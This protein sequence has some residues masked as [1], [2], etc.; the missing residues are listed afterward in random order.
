MRRRIASVGQ[1]TISVE[2]TEKPW[3]LGVD[4]LVVT[5]GAELGQ[6][7]VAL[8]RHNE[9]FERLAQPAL[10]KDVNTDR[11]VTLRVNSLGRVQM[12]VLATPHDRFGRVSEVSVE[13]AIRS[14][15]REVIMYRAQE[16]ALPL[17]AAGE[18]SGAPEDIIYPV[19][20]AIRDAVP[21][22]PTPRLR[23]VVLFG[24]D[25]WVDNVHQRGQRRRRA[26]PDSV[27]A[28]LAGG[29]S[30]DLVDPN[31]AIPLGRDRLGVGTYA[32]ML[33]AVIA[34]RT[35]ETPLSVGVFG[36][37]GSGKS[38]FMGLVHGQID[39]LSRE[40]RYC[41]NVTQIGF[42]AWHYAEANLW[43]SLADVIFAGLAGTGPYR[44]ELS[45]ELAK[46]D[47]L[48]EDLVATSERARAEVTQLKAE[49]DQAD[50]KHVSGAREVLAALSQSKLVKQKADATWRHLGVADEVEQARLLSAQLRDVHGDVVA[51]RELARTRRGR[52]ALWAAAAVLG[53]S[54][55]AALLVPVA[56]MLGGAVSAVIAAFGI[57]ALARAR[58]GIGELRRLGEDL[59]AGLA[60]P[61]SVALMDKLRAAEAE[62]E[63]ATARLDEVVARIG[64]LG[65]R[66]VDTDPGRRVATFV[67]D[68]ADGDTYTRGLGVV[69]TLRKD[70]E[71]LVALLAQWRATPVGGQ[72]PVDRVV[73]YIDDL[74]RCPPR[75][76]VEV[77]EAVHILLAMDLFTV[78]IGVDPGWLRRCVEARYADV[79]GAATPADYLEKIINIPFTLPPMA[80]GSLGTLL[81][82]MV[83]VAVVPAE[84]VAA[85]AGADPAPSV[86]AVELT[87]EPGSE[88][89]A[90]LPNDPPLALT[91]R[92]LDLLTAL[93]PLI[94][95]PRAAKRLLNTYR[96]VR[97]TR[98]LTDA[99]TFLGDEATPGDH[100]AV[101]VLL[102]IIAAVPALVDEVFSARPSPSGAGGLLHRDPTSQWRDFV[103]DL[104]PVDG[105]CAVVGVVSPERTE[106]WTRLH[107]GLGSVTELVAL[108][109]MERFQ[110]W[111]PHVRRFSYA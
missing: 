33:A 46:A 91:E 12:V 79:L 10:L 37:W 52:T 103:A 80:G 76:V 90:D 88:I 17:M 102:G 1:V 109:T 25:Q 49:I 3:D 41:T 72:R 4:A 35:T 97:A 106:S 105:R 6:V 70:F 111:A 86:T 47:R 87:A 9:E 108:P 71:Q 85:E 18:I 98:D 75:Q 20:R 21:D 45:R 29:A 62:Q 24:Q 93:D 13:L 69:S 99:A 73:L 8:A 11:P 92:E 104:L 31:K 38:F 57:S 59:R 50:A 26:K 14:A 42:N 81:R 78:V 53:V 32:A 43:A 100:Q 67:A 19:M 30:T 63:V 34:D 55:G 58:K 5:V 82:S 15:I 22:I 2:R 60:T 48:R 39:A 110:V 77:L 68:R 27:S 28:E 23:E 51:V 96:M 74:D 54:A 101:I 107:A 95:T 44:D 36:P 89:S 61:E 7:G 66:L 40:G 94:T 65:K 16:V 83:P 84:E 56:T 64:E